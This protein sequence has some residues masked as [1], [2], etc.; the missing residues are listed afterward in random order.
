MFG[1]E[2]AVDVDPGTSVTDALRRVGV[3]ILMSCARGVCGTCETVVVEGEPDHRDSILSDA[4]QATCD[5]FFP[6]VSRSRSDRL[7]IAV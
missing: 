1:T 7:V 3:D 4:E 2:I 6:C 5:S